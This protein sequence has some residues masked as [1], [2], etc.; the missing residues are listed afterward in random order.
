LSTWA[1]NVR[2]EHRV[3]VSQNHERGPGH[4]S[5]HI[6]E[7]QFLDWSD[8]DVDR[9]VDKC[10]GEKLLLVRQL[11]I[12]GTIEDLACEG[13]AL[14]CGEP[15]GI[16]ASA[17]SGEYRIQGFEKVLRLAFKSCLVVSVPTSDH[18]A[19]SRHSR[20]E[21][22]DCTDYTGGNVFPVQLHI[23]LLRAAARRNSGARCTASPASSSP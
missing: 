8:L 16:K 19:E 15:R 17:H 22:L 21:R 4:L 12:N 20:H 10:V 13:L 14:E 5:K 23:L 7:L 3:D 9:A 11:G 2:A 18:L 1:A 6:D